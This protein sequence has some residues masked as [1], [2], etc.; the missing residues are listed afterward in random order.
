MSFYPDTDVNEDDDATISENYYTGLIR[1]PNLHV[2]LSGSWE[3]LVGQQDTFLHILEYE[4]YGG[5]DKTTQLV[6]TSK[7]CV[8]L[9]SLET[10]LIDLYTSSILRTIKRCFRTSILDPSS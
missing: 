8:W 10:S 1:D 6:K 2:K 4:N 3:T 9:T 7:V 5:Y